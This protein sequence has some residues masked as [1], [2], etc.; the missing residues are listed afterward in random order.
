[1]TTSSTCTT[2]TPTNNDDY[3]IVSTASP[4]RWFHPTHAI[5]RHV[6]TGETFEWNSR[7]HRKM[8]HLRRIIRPPLRQFLRLLLFSRQNNIRWWCYEPHIVTWWV[9]LTN[10]LANSFWIFSSVFAVWPNI[11]DNNID[12]SGRTNYAGGI[13]AGLFMI[14]SCYLACVEAMNHTY[15][16]IHQHANADKSTAASASPP[17]NTAAT[18]RRFVPTGMYYGRRRSPVVGLYRDATDSL[19]IEKQRKKLLRLGYP[20]VEVITTETTEA[21]TAG[22]N[23]HNTNDKV[24]SDETIDNA[25]SK[26]FK[27]KNN[28]WRGVDNNNGNQVED[29][30]H[31]EQMELIGKQ[32]KI[33]SNNFSCTT[34]ITAVAPLA[35]VQEEGHYDWWTWDP[36]NPDMHNAGI[37]MAFISFLCAIVY[38]IPMCAVWPMAN[39]NA[40]EGTT[41]FFVDILQVIPYIGF[42]AIGHVYIF[43]AAGSWWKPRWDSIGYSI[44]VLNTVGAYGFLFC[45][46]LAIPGT[47]GAT[48]CP[49]MAKWGSSFA[50]FWGSVFYFLG[51]VLMWLEF[52]NPQPISN[53][54]S[55]QRRT[56]STTT[57]TNE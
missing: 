52:A 12:V 25:I 35:D 4:G 24:L 19:Q 2:T 34:T 46:A 17:N 36:Y 30:D 38:L 9:N 6:G 57:G 43:E 56:V 29:G 28:K 54:C 37:L 13:L 45:G 8:R 51:G 16:Q 23:H 21:G 39:N 40:N 11:V 53:I 33:L 14:A 41:L 31:E 15:S 50:C 1:M 10:M 32:L 20:I 48:C 49:N 18:A 5:L 27:A 7:D 22:N 3:E 44:A 47:V 42:A 55:E 26:Y